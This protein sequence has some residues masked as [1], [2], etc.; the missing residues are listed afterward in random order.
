MLVYQAVN[1]PYYTVPTVDSKQIVDSGSGELGEWVQYADLTLN[2]RGA[3]TSGTFVTLPKPFGDDKYVLTVPY[4]SK[5]A[6]GFTPAQTG[7]WIAK[8]KA[9]L[10]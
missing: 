5:T 1:P 4:S 8:G 9:S 7:D 6:T 10:I 2:Q 3:C